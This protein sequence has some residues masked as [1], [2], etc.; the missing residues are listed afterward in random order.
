MFTVCFIAAILLKLKKLILFP[1]N[2]AQ[3]PILKKTNVEFFANLLK[4]K[5]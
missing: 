5:N 2:V 4:K 3:Q 1:I